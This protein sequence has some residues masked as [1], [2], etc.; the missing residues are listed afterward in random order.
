MSHHVDCLCKRVGSIIVLMLK[1]GFTEKHLKAE[2]VFHELGII[3]R[4]LAGLK[5][6]HVFTDIWCLIEYPLLLI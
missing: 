4:T 3:L 1:P 5:E 6:N 2:H